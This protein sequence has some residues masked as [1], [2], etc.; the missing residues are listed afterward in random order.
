MNVVDNGVGHGIDHFQEFNK[1]G[2]LPSD[3]VT[4]KDEAKRSAACFWVSTVKALHGD[5]HAIDCMESKVNILDMLARCSQ[6]HPHNP[7]REECRSAHCF[8]LCEAG[9]R[10]FTDADDAE[11]S[12]KVDVTDKECFRLCKC[13]MNDENVA[14]LAA[15]QILNGHL[16]RPRF[17]KR[18][19][20][21]IFASKKRIT[22]TRNQK[23]VVRK[24]DCCLET[25]FPSMKEIVAEDDKSNAQCHAIANINDSHCID[26][27]DVETLPT[28]FQN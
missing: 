5:Y 19:H 2:R 12:V 8:A 16:L 14:S 1:Q 7:V 3:S 4:T 21:L 28:S 15:Q 26:I 20:L 22:R 6:I 23:N 11:A 24:K 27:V 9:T 25:M 18:S 10:E 13:D 17:E